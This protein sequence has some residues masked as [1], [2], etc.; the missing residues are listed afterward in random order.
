MTLI[1]GE[2]VKDLMS[3]VIGSNP[4]KPDEADTSQLKLCKRAVTYD[5]NPAYGIPEQVGLVCRTV[6]GYVMPEGASGF[7]VGGN[8]F[9]SKSGGLKAIIDGRDV[10]R[11]DFNSDTRII[12]DDRVY[13]VEYIRAYFD[14]GFAS[15]H[16]TRIIQTESQVSSQQ[17]DSV[18]NF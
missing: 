7:E 1:S 13:Q 18:L 2:E 3:E 10:K 12:F 6:W 4:E 15:L 14:R 8:H 9:I 17:P 11:K 5:A 16:E